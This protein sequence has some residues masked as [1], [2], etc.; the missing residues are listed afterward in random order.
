MEIIQKPR[1][2]GK[3]MDLIIRSAKE[4]IPIITPHNPEII[5]KMAK[6]LGYKIP[7]P[8]NFY[9]LRN[10]YMS[11][12]YYYDNFYRIHKEVLL[13]DIDCILEKAVNGLKIKCATMTPDHMSTNSN[14][15]LY[16]SSSSNG[17]IK[18]DLIIGNNRLGENT[19]ENNVMNQ[20]IF[21]W[22]YVASGLQKFNHSLKIPV[23]R[24]Y[25]IIV[26]NKVILV[27]FNDCKSEK[28][29][30]DKKDTFDLRRGLFI[31]IAKHMYKKK[32]TV[33]GIEHK[34]T[35]L[36]YEKR[37]VEI[38]ENAI[39]RHYREEKEKAK[40]LA[41]ENERKLVEK[42]KKEKKMLKIKERA[43]KNNEEAIELIAEA[44][45]RSRES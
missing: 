28:V 2:C 37:Y 16:A 36:S 21:D 4:N 3:T 9:H 20:D 29:V 5:I 25:R 27:N 42:R 33:E 13:D 10:S 18:D 11:N 1:G 23:I 40:A 24:S 30:C 8:I 34:A 19:M 31:A 17:L 6:D 15:L 14:Q 45:K 32:Y 44:V 22:D 12:S 39:K 35:E 38:V 26:P 7:E 43:K 41:L